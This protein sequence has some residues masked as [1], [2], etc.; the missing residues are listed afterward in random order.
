MEYS[1]PESFKDISKCYSE[2][3]NLKKVLYSYSCDSKTWFVRICDS[4]DDTG[5]IGTTLDNLALADPDFEL[6]K[7]PGSILLAQLFFLFHPK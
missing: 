7:G 1:V 4:F 6:R 3:R 5:F 2:T